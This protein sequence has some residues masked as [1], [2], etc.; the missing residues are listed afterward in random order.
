MALFS[1]NGCI[2]KLLPVDSTMKINASSNRQLDVSLSVSTSSKE[3]LWFELP[4]AFVKAST[5]SLMLVALG[6][7]TFSFSSKASNALAA[8]DPTTCPP[9]QEEIIAEDKVSERAVQNVDSEQQREEFEKWKSKTYALTVPLRVVAL[10]GSVPPAWIKDFIQ[11]QGKRLKLSVQF[12]GTLEDVYSELSRSISKVDASPKS[13]ITADLIT[14][15]DSW[16]DL[17]IN[18]SII[19]PMQMAEDHDWFKGLSAKWKV[20]L[21]DSENYLKAFS[22]GDAWVAVGWSSDILPAAKRMSNVAVIAPTS[23]ASLWADLWAVPATTKCPP[24]EKLGGRIRGPSPLIHQWLDFCLQPARELP[25]KQGVYPG[26]LPSAL[27]NVPSEVLP[28]G[29]PKLTTNLISGIPPPDILHKCEF[30]EP[31]SESALTDYEWLIT[32]TEKPRHGFI[33]QIF[34]N[35]FHATKMKLPSLRKKID[36]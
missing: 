10:Q 8:V 33:Q 35:A 21:F 15:G 6:I 32:T 17:L 25:F 18:K 30:L 27:E 24:M 26:S 14:V 23:G 9:L 22:V 4:R 31:L 13:A 3:C 7:F 29:A 16:L 5:S 1:N 12:R 28:K 20:L 19:E 36:D 2:E 11:S 34:T